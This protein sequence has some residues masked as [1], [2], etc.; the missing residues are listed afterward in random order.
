MI[1]F[2]F[3]VF[4]K[5]TDSFLSFMVLSLTCVICLFFMLVFTCL[6]KEDREFFY[7]GLSKFKI[8]KG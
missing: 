4:N 7:D 6:K 2:V 3:L 8:K 5:W 1:S